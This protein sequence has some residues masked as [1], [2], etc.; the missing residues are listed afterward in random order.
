MLTWSP[1]CS[2][3]LHPDVVSLT[4]AT[5]VASNMN[6]SAEFAFG[7]KDQTFLFMKKVKIDEWLIQ[8]SL[9]Q[10]ERSWDIRKLWT[11]HVLEQ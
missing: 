4:I 5:M 10:M 2:F 1:A 7:R 11:A 9:Q 8:I 6:S 3:F